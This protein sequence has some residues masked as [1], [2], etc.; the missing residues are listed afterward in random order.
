M[1]VCMSNLNIYFNFVFSL[2]IDMCIHTV[3]V[4]KKT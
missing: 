4:M 1:C 2:C 3:G